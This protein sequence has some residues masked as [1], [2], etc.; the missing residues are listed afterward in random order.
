[1]QWTRYSRTEANSLDD[2]NTAAP[3]NRYCLAG[4]QLV[5]LIV[6]WR[7]G[8]ARDG[9]CHCFA[10]ALLLP[11]EFRRT[12]AHCH[13]NFETEGN[14]QLNHGAAIYSFKSR[15]DILREKYVCVDTGKVEKTAG[16][17]LLPSV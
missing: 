2:L 13:L 7:C 5:A 6:L 17:K 1:M 4:P 11:R 12:C 16:L 14:F 10:F 9:P 8:H 3:K 15:K